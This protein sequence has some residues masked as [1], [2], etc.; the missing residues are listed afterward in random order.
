MAK[1][2]FGD[3]KDAALIRD[4]DAIHVFMAHLYRDRTD[5]EAYISET[6]DLAP[7]QKWIAAHKDEEF[8]YTF[9]HVIVATVL[10]L[11]VERPK[12]NRFI[13]DRKYYQRNEN[14]VSFIVKRQFTEEAS[15]GMAV[16]KGTEDDTIFTV[17]EKIKQQVIPCKN[18]ENSGT[19]D[20]MDFITK[21]PNFL[22][23]MVLSMIRW[24]SVKGK[25]P[26]SVTEGD[27]NHSSVFVTNLGS[28][29]L[30]CGYHHLSD[31]G[32]CSIFVVIGE[33]K[34]TPTFHDDGT[35]TLRDTLDIGLTI[36]ERIA[37]G[38]YYAKTV[39]LMKYILEHP[40]TLE[41]PFKTQTEMEVPV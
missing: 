5:N 7:M 34:Q 35:F 4:M 25:L 8:K 1:R 33:K 39:K 15:E 9:F 10:K 22:R 27:S 38:F 16:I 14:V 29:G 13:S 19:E 23:K 31:Y 21:M 20:G 32:T 28:I 3:R 26:R 18:G 30:K 17:H 37:D 36:D 12:L 24:L 40:E 41:V 2:R 6:I 11:L